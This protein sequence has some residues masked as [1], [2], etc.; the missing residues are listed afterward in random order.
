MRYGFSIPLQRRKHAQ[1][2]ARFKAWFSAFGRL[3]VTSAWSSLLPIANEM[4]SNLSEDEFVTLL[5][6]HQTAMYAYIM[7]IFP[8]R[9][10]A[11]DVLQETVIVMWRKVNEFEKGTNF[12]AWAFKIAYWQTM[13]HL[14]RVKRAG[15][16]GLEPEYLELL[17]MEAETGLGDLEVRQQAL[18]KCIQALPAGD[19]AILQAHYYR[20]EPISQ[21]AAGLGRSRDG[22]KQVLMR[23][24]RK[25]KTC[26]KRQLPGW[27]TKKLPL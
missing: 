13:A 1:G 23:I 14:K 2:E 24:R 8:D 4:K 20:K 22:I 6:R 16:V 7:T 26:I 15:L 19:A 18:R 17:A 27:G 10:A 12:K 9:F 21:I 11:Q 25:L 5:T 3:T